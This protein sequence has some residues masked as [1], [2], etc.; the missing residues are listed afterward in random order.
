MEADFVAAAKAELK[1]GSPLEICAVLNRLPP[2]E[3]GDHI[4]IDAIDEV[5]DKLYRR[6]K[7]FIPGHRWLSEDPA[8]I[9]GQ[10]TSLFENGEIC[11]DSET[12][13]WTSPWTYYFTVGL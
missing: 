13:L 10:L 6:K 8:S 7:L 3:L 1:P 5:M 12:G 4:L 2:S 11:R 9:R